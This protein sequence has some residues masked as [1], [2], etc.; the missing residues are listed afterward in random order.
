MP[1]TGKGKLVETAAAIV[2]GVKPA[3]MAKPANEEE[4]N[5]RLLAELAKGPRL[6]F[7]DNVRGTVKSQSGTNSLALR[8]LR[9]PCRGA[10]GQR[11]AALRRGAR[12]LVLRFR[13]RAKQLHYG[14]GLVHDAEPDVVLDSLPHRLRQWHQFCVADRGLT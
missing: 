6:V 8:L 5:K 3:T 12:L 2:L 1:G 14:V 11:T 4:M 13:D 7:F 9:A 10:A